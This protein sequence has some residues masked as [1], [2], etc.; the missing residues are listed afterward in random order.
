MAH[1]REVDAILH[2]VRY[3]KD[4]NVS[5]VEGSVDPLTDIEIVDT[6][7]ILADLQTLEKRIER[8]ERLLK[9]LASVSIEKN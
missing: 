3:F 1:I 2:V 7:L 6:E 4:P 8:T 9:K 5:K